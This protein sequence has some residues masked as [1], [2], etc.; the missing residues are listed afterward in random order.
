ME[1]EITTLTDS[2]EEIT[3]IEIKKFIDDFFKV[4]KTRVSMQCWWFCWSAY[5]WNKKICW[6][7]C[8][9]LWNYSPEEI[10]DLKD[11]LYKKLVE[12]WVNIN[13]GVLTEKVAIAIN[14]ALWL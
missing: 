6:A 2:N 12:K 4:S 7:N 1:K 5:K 8:I 10:D 13:Y 9:N 11:D 14:K 3:N